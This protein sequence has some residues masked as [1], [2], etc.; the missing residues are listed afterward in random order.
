[1][2]ILGK[3]NKGG[4]A[5]KHTMWLI[6]M[7]T[8]ILLAVVAA[9]C[10][11][12]A[13]PQP[14]ELAP[15]GN[16]SSVDNL[17]S[18]DTPL[19]ATQSSTST[20]LPSNT[21]LPTA[22][23]SPSHTPLPTSTSTA[24]ETPLPTSTLTP[25]PFDFARVKQIMLDNGLKLRTTSEQ[26]KWVCPIYQSCRVYMNPYETLIVT[27][28]D[29]KSILFEGKNYTSGSTPYHALLADLFGKEVADTIYQNMPGR[30]GVIY[31]SVDNNAIKIFYPSNSMIIWVAPD[32]SVD[33]IHAT[34]AT[35]G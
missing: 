11:P 20:P 6:S 12:L 26:S 17:T 16:P 5:I 31:L 4:T 22:T 30:G 33:D 8:V 35:F 34:E 2:I 21:P 28:T 25:I 29:D 3:S 14:E 9:G 1:M 23:P 13:A 18:S 15:V 7:I 32:M 19:A 24:T 10:N 27:V